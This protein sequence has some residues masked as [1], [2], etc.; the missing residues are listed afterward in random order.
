[1][2]LLDFASFLPVSETILGVCSENLFKNLF[3]DVDIQ[4]ELKDSQIGKSELS[5]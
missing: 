3:I 4:R 1:M 5:W 2:L